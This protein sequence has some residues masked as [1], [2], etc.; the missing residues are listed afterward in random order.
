MKP[1]TT[2]L[3]VKELEK[4]KSKRSN[5]SNFGAWS[6]LFVA[7]IWLARLYSLPFEKAPT[8]T[9]SWF[10]ALMFVIPLVL[11]L[12]SFFIIVQHLMDKK[13]SVLFEALLEKKDSGL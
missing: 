10:Y 12:H 13:F 2:V 6:E 7:I 11:L 9:F 1:E 8:L 4:I 5:F 3:L